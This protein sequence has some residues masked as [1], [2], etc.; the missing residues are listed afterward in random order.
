MNTTITLEHE[1]LEEN[2]CKVLLNCLAKYNELPIIQCHEVLT[3]KQNSLLT[4]C[5]LKFNQTKDNTSILNIWNKIKLH[6]PYI[7]NA[8]LDIKNNYN[9]SINYYIKSNTNELFNILHFNPYFYTY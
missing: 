7:D 2:S 3:I 9:G 1:K 8:K 4:T 6:T 5:I